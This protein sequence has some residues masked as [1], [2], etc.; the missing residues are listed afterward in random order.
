[1]SGPAPSPARSMSIRSGASRSSLVHQ[2]VGGNGRDPALPC[3]CHIDRL[4][5][6]HYGGCVRARGGAGTFV[7]DIF[8]EVDEEVRR[9][10]LKKL[11]DRYGNYAVAAA[12]LL[13]VGGVARGGRPVWGGE[14]NAGQGRRVRDRQHST[15][16]Q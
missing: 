9:E 6:R 7:S 5:R 2:W 10:Q 8:H 11:W 13:L 3:L 16:T 14:K 4:I 15:R 1:T 12:G